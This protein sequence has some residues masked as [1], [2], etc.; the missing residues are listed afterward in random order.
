MGG[1]S[2]AS[3][4]KLPSCIYYFGSQECRRD[5]LANTLGNC[6]GSPLCF[7]VCRPA[8]VQTC[9]MYSAR[10]SQVPGL[11]LG[12]RDA[13]GEGGFGRLGPGG[14]HLSGTRGH[15][16]GLVPMTRVQGAEEDFQL[17]ARRLAS[18]LCH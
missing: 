14:V 2:Q 1:R 8:Q 16:D 11:S 9:T 7:A 4:E 12:T 6:L 3:R 18:A 5:R 10:A 15:Q 13:G 17:G